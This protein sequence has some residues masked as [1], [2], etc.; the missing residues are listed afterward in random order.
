MTLIVRL[1]SDLNE[2]KLYIE[3]SHKVNVFYFGFQISWCDLLG[4]K[5]YLYSPICGNM[6]WAAITYL[7]NHHLYIFKH[8][9]SYE[10]KNDVKRDFEQAECQ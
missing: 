9:K 1:T 2:N 3:S 4:S 10:I 8:F 7:G 6:H 5:C